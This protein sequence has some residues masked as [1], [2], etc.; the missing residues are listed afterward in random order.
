MSN[1]GAGLLIGRAIRS[2]ASSSLLFV[3]AV[4]ACSPAVPSSETGAPVI[5]ASADTTSSRPTE[6]AA[7]APAPSRLTL[8]DAATCPVTSPL[9]LGASDTNRPFASSSLAFGNADLWVVPLQVDG[10]FRADSRSVETDGSM[11]TKFGWWRVAPGRLVITGRRI[12]ASASPVRATIPE[13]YGNSGFQSSA[14]HFPTEGCW[15]LTGTAGGLP[16]TFVVFV[17]RT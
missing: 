4:A 6:P 7:S 5:L 2:K 13:G 8:A 3:L 10:I 15:E 1:L 9:G 12:D 16:L 14:V 11:G 17:I